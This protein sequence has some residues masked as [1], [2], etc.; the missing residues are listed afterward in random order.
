MIYQTPDLAEIECYNC[1][2]LDT[3]KSEFVFAVSAP[4]NSLGTVN[5]LKLAEF[6]PVSIMSNC[7]RSHIGEKRKL[8]LWWKKLREKSEPLTV[9]RKRW[10]E[11]YG[12]Y[13]HPID[14]ANIADLVSSGCGF[15]LCDGPLN[16]FQARFAHFFSL[17]RVPLVDHQDELYLHALKRYNFKLIEVGSQAAFY[18]NGWD[19]WTWEQEEAFFAQGGIVREEATQASVIKVKTPRPRKPR[20]ARLGVRKRVEIPAEPIP[21]PINPDGGLLDIPIFRGR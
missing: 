20:V 17:I 10:C 2:G 16:N 8:V 13:D 9:T 6:K 3:F 4:S 7:W 11:T 12:G 15:K 21:A 1:N 19:N 18:V 5:M 14:K